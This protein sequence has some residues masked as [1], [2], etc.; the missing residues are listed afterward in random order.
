MSFFSGSG[1]FRVTWGKVGLTMALFI[2]W[3]GLSKDGWKVLTQLTELG[4]DPNENLETQDC[5]DEDFLSLELGLWLGLQ[6]TP[7][8]RP[9]GSSLGT[10]LLTE[11]QKYFPKCSHRNVL[12][13][14][15]SV[16]QSCLTI[17]DPT[18]CSMPGFPVHHQLP[19][20]TQT[21]VY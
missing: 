17:C 4:S 3:A 6:T 16:A 7:N 9:F 21:H 2:R 11:N 14:F 1:S 19:E 5:I 12:V 20:L 13:Q 15:S 18:D 10:C 8:G